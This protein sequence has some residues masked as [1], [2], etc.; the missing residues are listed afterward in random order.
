MGTC[1]EGGVSGLVCSHGKIKNGKLMNLLYLDFET[2][3]KLTNE[4]ENLSS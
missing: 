2:Y 1:K 3:Y 4:Y